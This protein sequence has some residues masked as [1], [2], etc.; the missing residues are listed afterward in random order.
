[1][2]QGAQGCNTAVKEC[3]RADREGSKQWRQRQRR[4]SRQLCELL[5]YA[6]RRLA[7]S[8]IRVSAIPT[9]G[10][11]QASRPRPSRDGNNAEAMLALE[12]SNAMDRFFL[13]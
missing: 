4:L 2:I 1:M 13:Q 10:A 9:C 8:S 5:T 6:G 11:K 12:L 7:G 3:S